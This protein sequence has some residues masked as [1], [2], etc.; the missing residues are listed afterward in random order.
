MPFG[1]H[2]PDYRPR[3]TI[4]AEMC[5]FLADNAEYRSGH[6]KYT[7]RQEL[8]AFLFRNTTFEHLDRLHFDGL[9]LV[10]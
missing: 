6:P 7:L 10:S 8:N 2:N 5:R 9:R 1:M 3:I 4:D